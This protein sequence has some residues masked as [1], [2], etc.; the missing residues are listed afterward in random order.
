MSYDSVWVRTVRCWEVSVASSPFGARGCGFRAP[1]CALARGRVGAMRILLHGLLSVR[2]RHPTGFVLVN[3]LLGESRVLPDG[4]VS[5][6]QSLAFPCAYVSVIVLVCKFECVQAS[7]VSRAVRLAIVVLRCQPCEYVL[8][9]FEL[10][11]RP[12]TFQPH[13][14]CLCHVEACPYARMADAS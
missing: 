1:P 2:R 5:W 4:V 6:Q 9:C 8:P 7:P 11:S 10:H 14:P 13:Q 3:T 12:P